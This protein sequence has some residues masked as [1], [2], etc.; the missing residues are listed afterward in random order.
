MGRHIKLEFLE[1][2]N[3][4]AKLTNRRLGFTLLI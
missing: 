1:I 2:L 3:L 4:T